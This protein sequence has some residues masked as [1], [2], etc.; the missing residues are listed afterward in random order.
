MTAHA[1]RRHLLGL[2]SYT[3]TSSSNYTFPLS[4]NYFIHLLHAM[5]LLILLSHK[6]SL[7][8]LRVWRMAQLSP[9]VIMKIIAWTCRGCGNEPTVMQLVALTRKEKPY[10]LFLSET[11]ISVSRMLPILNR[12]GFS[13][14]HVYPS[15]NKPR[16][17]ALAWNNSVHIDIISTCKYLIHVSISSPPLTILWMASFTYGSPYLESKPLSWGQLGQTCITRPHLGWS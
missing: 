16:G 1:Y 4:K 10:I 11:K 9:H 3:S 8:C 15:C 5:I 6:T 13:N 2:D 17:L 7:I 12:L 14:S